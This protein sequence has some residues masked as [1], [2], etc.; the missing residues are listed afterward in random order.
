MGI[1]VRP[2][3]NPSE[4]LRPSSID[5]DIVL[6]RQFEQNPAFKD[7]VKKIKRIVQEE[8][9][10]PHILAFH[11]KL[12]QITPRGYMYD[13]VT[14]EL[15]ENPVRLA[16]SDDAPPVVAPSRPPIPSL[17]RSTVPSHLSPRSARPVTHS[18]VS[19]RPPRTP[20]TSSRAAQGSSTAPPSVTPQLPSQR[21][22]MAPHFAAVTRDVQQLNPE[23]TP[24]ASSATASAQVA[25][26]P[27]S[28]AEFGEFTSALR[29]LPPS[30]QA[31]YYFRGNVDD[32][33]RTV[34]TFIS[35]LGLTTQQYARFEAAL[36]YISDDWIPVF[37]DIGLSQRDAECLRQLVENGMSDEMREVMQ[38]A[39]GS[40]EAS[41]LVS[42]LSTERS[43]T[44]SSITSSTGSIDTGVTYVSP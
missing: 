33:P 35:S 29:E 20:D 16:T 38:S 32:L 9:A 39:M 21:P 23:P 43:E 41:S 18:Q 12:D 10:V 14:H 19:Q 31:E 4:P 40:A 26:V 5:V 28:D 2:E 3:W 15:V 17:S 37:L 6:T 1:A 13:P 24:A 42:E 25:V 44:E 22:S 34:R 30:Y 8:L 7:V 11:S 27:D 36:D